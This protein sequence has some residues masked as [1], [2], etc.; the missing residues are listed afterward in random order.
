[1]RQFEGTP[2]GDWWIVLD[3][4]QGRQLGTGWDAT[5]EH[6]IILASSLAAK[7]LNEDHPV[8]LSINGNEPEWIPPRRNEYQ[9]RSLLKALSVAAPSEM[10]L[11]DYL[12]R[13]GTSLSSHC[14]LIIIT[15]NPDVEWTQSLMPLMWR[16][17]MPTVFL[18]D[19]LTFGGTANTKAVSEVFQ[20]MNVPC[21][22]IPREMLDKPQARPGHEGEW[23][24]R[25]SATGKAFAVRAAQEDW[26]GLE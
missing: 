14:S 26:R 24:W 21:H 1:V 4:D 17:I 2:A 11:K 19:P 16:G 5:E 13:A 15:S 6:A 8:G 23:E 22:V 10:S 20:A 25:I 18:F 9:L 3:L 12:Q 7:G